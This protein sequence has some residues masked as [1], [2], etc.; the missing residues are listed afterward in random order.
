MILNWM[1]KAVKPI[2]FLLFIFSACTIS[3]QKIIER[4]VDLQAS[5]VE[6]QA[7]LSLIAA[8]ADFK[9]AY[10][11][12]LIPEGKKVDLF[13]SNSTVKELLDQLL[14]EGMT[15][16]QSGEHLIILGPKSAKN[17]LKLKGQIFDLKNHKPL[18]GVLVLEVDEVNATRS[19]PNGNFEMTISGKRTP[20]GLL[21]VRTA[22]HDTVVF[23]DPKSESANIYLR[24]LYRDE[25][26]EIRKTDTLR[27]VEDLGLT[28]LLVSKEKQAQARELNFLEQRQLQASLIPG[29]S[30]NKSV[31]GIATNKISINGLA[32]YQ[33]GLNGAE[34]GIGANLIRKDMKG[35]QAAGLVNLVG[36]NANGVQMAG[37]ANNTLRSFNG[38]QISGLANV[39][40]DT[41]SGLQLTGGIN[42]LRGGMK[43]VQISGLGNITTEDCDGAQ[44]SGGFNVTVGDVTSFQLSG[45]LNYGR[46]VMGSQFSAGINITPGD[47]SG[48]QL[49]LLSNYAQNVEGGQI[50]LI[51]VASKKTVGRQVGLINYSTRAEG[52]QLGLLNFSDTI[53]GVSIG[54]LSVALHGYHR[55]DI[56]INEMMPV[57]ISLRTGTSEFYNTFTYGRSLDSIKYS[58]DSSDYWAFG[59]GFGGEINWPRKHTVNIELTANHINERKHFIEAVN[60]VGR[61]E[62]IYNFTIIDRITISA[63]P[64]FNVL[65]SDWRDPETG[66]YLT[67]IAPNKLF[68]DGSE[69]LLMQGWI[70]WRAGVGVR[71]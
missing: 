68:E 46:N 3:A 69:D 7:A 26:M 71:F 45:L 39:V 29:V 21:V 12:D 60:I 14:G 64:S 65:F 35:F 25:L 17:K 54:F 6:L 67:T 15:Y 43:G 5:N 51:N 27:Q 8:A 19:G 9:L 70:G 57:N 13:A 44:V 18:E 53:K 42:M 47:V 30:T 22:F 33:G 11:S 1:V 58:L 48:G 40:W 61:L 34:F 52:G 10:N 41:L 38:A 49:G 31:S 59:Y 4:T 20:T 23:V 63:G 24:P 55:A 28:K 36:G 2:L 16:K 37:L 66:E 50:G 32:G 56:Y 62:V